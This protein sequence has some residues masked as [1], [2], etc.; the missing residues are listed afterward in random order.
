[1]TTKKDIVTQFEIALHNATVKK[2]THSRHAYTFALKVLETLNDDVVLNVRQTQNAYNIGD[3][4]E[5]VLKFHLDMNAS[6]SAKGSKDLDKRSYHEVKA[7]ASANRYP[8]GFKKPQGFLAVT[9]NGVYYIKKDFVIQHW[10]TFRH[11]K[12]NDLMQ[13]TLATINFIIENE[14]LQKHYYSNL[15]GL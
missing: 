14:N 7:F 13:P 10:D 15:L 4:I 12:T 9:K 8:N 3:T 11:D 2:S 5:A 1:M 6:Y